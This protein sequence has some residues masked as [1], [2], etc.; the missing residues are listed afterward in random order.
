MNAFKKSV[1]A[2]ATIATLAT[3]AAPAYAGSK[4]W[5]R[6]LAAGV[7]VGV[8]LGIAG[9]LLHQRPRHQ[10]RHHYVQQPTYY[11]RQPVC[12]IQNEPLFDR[13]GNIVAHR[14]VQVCN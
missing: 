6:G 7:G 9:A 3:A 8:G 13:Y 12:H 4:H 1:I 11:V 5:K 14:R 10:S 2:L